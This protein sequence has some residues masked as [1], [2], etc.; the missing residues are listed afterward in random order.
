MHV[1]FVEP[2]FP[3]NQREFVRALRAAGARVTGIGE[4][5]RE[6]LDAELADWLYRYERIPSVTN[7]PALLAAVRRRLGTPPG[8][9]D[10]SRLARVY[11]ALLSEG[12]EPG[13][14]ASALVPY[15]FRGDDA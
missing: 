12:F 14:I 10:E 11:N 8:G 4:R 5:P 9:A 6:S 15:G 7:E 13:R 2:A 3:K 1:V